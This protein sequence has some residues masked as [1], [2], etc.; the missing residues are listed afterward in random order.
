MV[1]HVQDFNTGGHIHFQTSI[2]D[3]GNKR[4]VVKVSERL[5]VFEC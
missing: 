2:C 1:Y 5:V 3:L 4:I